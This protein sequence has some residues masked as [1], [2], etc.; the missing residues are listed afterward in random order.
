ML[1]CVYYNRLWIYNTHC[2]LAGWLCALLSLYSKKKKKQQLC[3]SKKSQA[4]QAQK[5]KEEVPLLC[6]K[7]KARPIIIQ[8]TNRKEAK[9]KKEESR[10]KFSFV[11]WFDVCVCV[12]SFPKTKKVAAAGSYRVLYDDLCVV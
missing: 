7:F 4:R 12:L 3:K 9:K 11:L 8:K 10:K 5:T 6:R 1:Y 2:T